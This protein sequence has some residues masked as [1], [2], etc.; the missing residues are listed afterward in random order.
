MTHN[1]SFSLIRVGLPVMSL[2]A[3]ACTHERVVEPTPPPQ[4]LLPAQQ[5]VEPT[6]ANPTSPMSSTLVGPTNVP[7][8]GEVE[9]ELSV[10]RVRPGLAP[11]LVKIQT[12]QG[13]TIGKGSMTETITDASATTLI[14]RW[15]LRYDAVPPSDVVVVVDWQTPAGGYHAELPWRFGRPDPKA[16]PPVTLPGE[17]RLPGGQSLGTPILSPNLPEKHP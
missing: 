3:I 14:R 2:V 10:G 8:K 12:P 5:A 13:T 9:L 11:I 6:E 15:T 4:E 1:T 7:A 16:K 17:V